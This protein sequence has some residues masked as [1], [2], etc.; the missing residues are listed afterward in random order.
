MCDYSLE[1]V[2]SREAVDGEDLVVRRFISGSKG[3]VSESDPTCAVCCKSGVEVTCQLSGEFWTSL[4]DR[5]SRQTT[6]FTGETP[7]VFHTLLPWT[8]GYGYKDGF[9]TATGRFLSL[10]DL[11]EGTRATVTKA[12]PTQILEAA[13]G[14]IA[15]EPEVR[16]TP[17]EA[18]APALV[19]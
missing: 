16:V 14:E 2:K 19:G 9:L 17:I 12:L 4:T 7:L 6:V 8:G 18:H 15:F 1:N 3:F 5:T 11:E 13:K 10:Q